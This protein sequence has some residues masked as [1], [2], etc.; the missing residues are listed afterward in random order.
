MPYDLT[1]P[2]FGPGSEVLTTE[3]P[4]QSEPTTKAEVEEVETEPETSVEEEGKVKY[5]RFKKFHDRA[6]EAEKEAAYWRSQAEQRQ[7]VETKETSNVPDYWKELY[8][9]SEAA[10]KAWRIQEKAQEELTERAERKAIEAVHQAQQ[11]EFIQNQANVEQLDEGFESLSEFVGRDL[12]AKEQSAV[13]DI[14]DEFTPK[15]SNGNYVKDALFPFEKAWEIYDMRNQ[16]SKAPQKAS[17]D[18]VANLTGNQTQGEPSNKSEAD[19][20][21]NPLD[22]SAYKR[23]I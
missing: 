8:G 5:S 2:A 17:R 15:Q 23:R 7:T 4:I 21:F 14:V 13:L 6:L 3:S 22:W 12:T 10:Q 9:E 16:M 11:E 20:S 19:K 1:K 18:S